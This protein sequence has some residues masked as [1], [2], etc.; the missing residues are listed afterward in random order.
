[1]SKPCKTLSTNTQLLHY[2]DMLSLEQ[3][4]SLEIISRSILLLHGITSNQPDQGKP[5]T[6]L[7]EIVMKQ[8]V[9]INNQDNQNNPIK[10][11]T[12]IAYAQMVK[13]CIGERQHFDVMNINDKGISEVGKDRY[14]LYMKKLESERDCGSSFLQ[15]LFETC[16]S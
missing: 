3:L 15:L 7:Q 10:S 9:L 14:D 16:N 2:C 11:A 4:V 1:M 6:Q 5:R 12:N 8:L 13:S